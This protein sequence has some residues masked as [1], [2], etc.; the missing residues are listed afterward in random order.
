MNARFAPPTLR[1]ALFAS[2]VFVAAPAAAQSVELDDF[3]EKLRQAVET[4]N[5]EIDFAEARIEGE[6]VVLS[7]VTL[8]PTGGEALDFETMTF[9]GV[10]ETPGG[11]YFV[12]EVQVPDVEFTEDGMEF[13]IQDISV[14][15]L[16][17]PAEPGAGQTL[18]DMVLYEQ[19]RTGPITVSRGDA[20]IFRMDEL[21][22]DVARKPE[23]AGLDA[24][25]R[26]NGIF[27]DLSVAENPKAR[28]TAEAM[29][30]E[31][32]TGSMMLNAG[33]TAETGEID[34]ADFTVSFDD[35]GSLAL[36]FN[37]SGYTLE[38]IE[39]VEETETAATTGGS[40]EATGMAMLGLMQQL[41]FNSASV[42]FED[43]GLTGRMLD[44]Y[45]EQQG[46]EA[47]QMALALK[48]MLPL[49]LGQV[50]DEAFREALRG[51]VNTFLDDPQSLTISAEPENPVPF[52]ML[53]G[54]GMTD[55]QRLTD[56]LGLEVW[57]NR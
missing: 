25:I 50:E 44:Y 14:A 54:A 3:T 7:D 28:V 13:L 2:I 9:G 22:I 4:G 40:D 55:P 1:S 37:I 45:G 27:I 35:L 36:A 38:F 57:A 46:V 26:A 15:G 43:D 16:E 20:A 47:E 39:A 33:W 34:L 49:V 31:Q 12:E 10:E 23:N 18:E 53:I 48:G 52:A 19:A 6:A 17:I 51:A 30:Y 8:T 21:V 42:R 41:T 11:G 32:L 56:V 24:M 29:G 5:A